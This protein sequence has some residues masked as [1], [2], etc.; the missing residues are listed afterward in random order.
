M[1]GRTPVVLRSM[2]AADG[3]LIFRMTWRVDLTGSK[4]LFASGAKFRKQA[5]HHWLINVWMDA[6]KLMKAIEPHTLFAIDHT[7]QA[8]GQICRAVAAHRARHN[9]SGALELQKDSV[10]SEGTNDVLHSQGALM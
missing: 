7:S 10:S 2:E 3:L 4:A 8:H 9:F 1:S 6:W 5:G